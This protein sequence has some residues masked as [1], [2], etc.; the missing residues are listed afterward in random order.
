MQFDP[1]AIDPTMWP[2]F[3]L[4]GIL[5]LSL[6]WDSGGDDD[7]SDDN[8]EDQAHVVNGTGGRDEITA[9]SGFMGTINAGRGSD[10]VTVDTGAVREGLGLE[11]AGL[12]EVQW[13][14]DNQQGSVFPG[15]PARFPGGLTVVNGGEGNDTISVESGAAHIVKGPGNDRVD[16]SGARLAAVFGDRGDIVTGSNQRGDDVDIQTFI[17]GRGEFRGGF[18]DETATAIG[19]GATLRGGFGDDTLISDQGAAH[20][21]GGPGN[22]VLYGAVREDA[23]NESRADR[24]GNFM[25]D[26]RD[27]LDGGDGDD[28]IH[29]SNNDIVTGAQGADDLRAELKP[30][31]AARLTDFTP[32]ED[33]L[34]VSI[35][36]NSNS[37]AAFSARI[38]LAEVNGASV[39]FVDGQETITMPQTGGMSIGFT[40]DG[41][42]SFQDINGD[43]TD[44]DSL[45]IVI[46][47]SAVPNTL[48]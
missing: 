26:A 12:S 19:D 34:W 9:D 8:D 7:D 6:L 3:A 24:F 11:R 35:Q 16:L 31:D 4:G 36:D 10:N 20:L 38:G 17:E 47:N 27:T 32:G 44:R 25:D 1:N 46:S 37:L 40:R 23:F 43:E 14:N 39:L 42:E 18:A 5:L 30:G 13:S 28:I 22:D 48:R 2:F 29:F 15:D 41:G 21:V 33:S 45:D